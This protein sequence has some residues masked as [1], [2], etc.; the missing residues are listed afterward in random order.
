MRSKEKA[1]DEDESKTQKMSSSC[2]Q[3]WNRTYSPSESVP[4]WDSGDAHQ[5][6]KILDILEK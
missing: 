3:A 1:V 6:L 4:G 5:K 2:C